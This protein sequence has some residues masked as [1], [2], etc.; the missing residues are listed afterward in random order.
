MY[1]KKVNVI[2]ENIRKMMEEKIEKAKEEE[3]MKNLTKKQ[4]KKYRKKLKKKKKRL[5]QENSEMEQQIENRDFQIQ[6]MEEAKQNDAISKSNML[7][8]QNQDENTNKAV[9]KRNIKSP[10]NRYIKTPNS[11]HYK[12]LPL[13]RKAKSFPQSHANK[14][15]RHRNR[16]KYLYSKHHIKNE[17]PNSENSVL[18]QKIIK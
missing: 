14:S 8:S 16:R 15:E 9:L 17:E 18:I 10:P 7:E 6:D 5:R 1:H 3:R 4:L 11:S 12:R 2:R 13:T